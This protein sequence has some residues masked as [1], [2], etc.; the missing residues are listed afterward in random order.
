MSETLREIRYFAATRSAV[1]RAIARRHGGQVLDAREPAS[2][3]AAWPRSQRWSWAR[4]R[5][6]ARDSEHTAIQAE[7]HA[8]G[9]EWAAVR[10]SCGRPRPYT[11]LNG[12]PMVVVHSAWLDVASEVRDQHGVLRLW[13]GGSESA[14]ASVPTPRELWEAATLPPVVRRLSKKDARAVRR[15]PDLNP[16][17]PTE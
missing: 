11:T 4:V 15:Q 12:R 6:V 9:V 10:R 17:V 1:V 14:N 13:A 7:L 2:A 5:V 16:P 3:S 8:L